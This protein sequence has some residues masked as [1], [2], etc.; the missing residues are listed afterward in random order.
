[1]NLFA[2]LS[3]AIGA[4]MAFTFPIVYTITSKWWKNPM[5]LVLFGLTTE[6][7]LVYAQR[8]YN[9]ITTHSAPSTSA[10]N[11]TVSV[12]AALT[13]SALLGVYLYVVDTQRRDE[14]E[15]Q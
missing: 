1:M 6:I 3:F 13:L 15:A 9:F 5:G 7:A 2:W 8:V 11:I 12:T 14:G 10:L 4:G